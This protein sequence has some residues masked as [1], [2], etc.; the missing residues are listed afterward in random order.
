MATYFSFALRIDS[1]LDARGWHCLLHCTSSYW[2]DLSINERKTALPLWDWVME[3]PGTIGATFNA[4]RTTVHTAMVARFMYHMWPVSRW[5]WCI[6]T[7]YGLVAN[8]QWL[9]KLSR[10]EW[11]LFWQWLELKIEQHVIF[12]L[13]IFTCWDLETLIF[14]PQIKTIINNDVCWCA[15]FRGFML[16]CVISSFI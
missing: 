2:C 16:F 3:L 9:Y 12:C 13:S 10:D 15:I 8:W 11:G 4:H 5:S 14:W 6:Q 7:A 1:S